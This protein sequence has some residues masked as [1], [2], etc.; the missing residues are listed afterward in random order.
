MKKILTIFLV[1]FVVLFF[2]FGHLYYEGVFKK[3]EYSGLLIYRVD[4]L[5][6]YTSNESLPIKEEYDLELR[7]NGKLRLEVG[8][9]WVYSI[10]Y[11]ERKNN[12]LRFFIKCVI[13]HYIK[14][15]KY[16]WRIIMM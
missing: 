6:Y 4:I 9:G 10:K 2:F 11:Y 15:E 5:E 16:I 3:E 7:E 14:M 13:L 12:F 1:I 8:S